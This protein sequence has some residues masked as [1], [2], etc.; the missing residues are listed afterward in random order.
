[1]TQ[2]AEKRIAGW[3]TG[4]FLFGYGHVRAVLTNNQHG[5]QPMFG[6]HLDNQ[7][8]AAI[9]I[10][11]FELLRRHLRSSVLAA[12]SVL[13][14]AGDAITRAY[15]PQKGAISLV[16]AV[17]SGQMIE[18]AMVGRNG[19]V[20]GFAALEPQPASYTAV[21]QIEGTAATIDIELL[22]QLAGARVSIRSLLLRH[23][24]ALLAQTQQIAACNALHS[25]EARFCRWLLAARDACGGGPLGATQESIAELLGV[26]RTSIC[27]VAHT[28]Q[29]AGLIR[30]RRGHIDILDEAALRQSACECYGHIAAHAARLA[31]PDQQPATRAKIA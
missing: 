15:F 29:Q 3:G 19:I 18:T 11:D 26:R 13:F 22:R 4:N 24:G 12:Q 30:T 8:L 25:L 1:M 2:I 27:L 14:A 20:G 5:G 7:L 10:E 6:N 17:A 31:N 16:V 23:E 9:P 28:M 21:V